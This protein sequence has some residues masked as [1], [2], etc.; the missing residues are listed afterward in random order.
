M[1]EQAMFDVQAGLLVRSSLRN[2]LEGLKFSG[3][4]I[5][6]IENKGLLSSYFL[7]KGDKDIIISLKNRINEINRHL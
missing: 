6:Y 3:E 5:D 1:T 7:I 2:V 4:N